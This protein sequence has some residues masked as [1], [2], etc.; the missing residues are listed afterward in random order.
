LVTAT[1]KVAESCVDCVK[2]V[3]VAGVEVPL[4]DPT[5]HVVRASVPKPA[6]TT[7]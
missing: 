6:L 5:E 7:L 3:H 1:L 2:P 4:Y